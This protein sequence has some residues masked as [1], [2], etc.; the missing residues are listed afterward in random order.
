MTYWMQQNHP[1]VVP[2]GGY[3]DV[4][5]LSWTFDGMPEDSWVAVTTQGC[6]DNY[7][8]KWIFLN[9]MHELVRAKRPRGIIVYGKFPDDWRDKFA[10]PIVVFPSY[11]ENRWEVNDYG[12]R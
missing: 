7:I 12:K 5:T 6:L 11:S 8:Q 1:T 2:N 10:V 9:G 4:E 3:G